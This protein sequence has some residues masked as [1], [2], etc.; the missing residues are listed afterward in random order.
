[1]GGDDGA[2]DL[3]PPVTPRAAKLFTE[4]A[5]SKNALGELRKKIEARI[6][7]LQG[8]VNQGEITLVEMA[9]RIYEL[10]WVRSELRKPFSAEKRLR[11]TGM[12][13]EHRCMENIK[14]CSDCDWVYCSIC[15]RTIGEFSS[16]SESRTHTKIHEEFGFEPPC[17]A[18]KRPRKDMT[19][20]E[21]LKRFN[22]KVVPK[23][24][25]VQFEKG[26]GAKA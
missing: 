22:M 4:K 26:S 18:E 7:F 5:S 24:A 8:R 16:I 6:K 21:F 15:D 13:V 14:Y 17:E 20:A 9:N 19:Y 3:S 12:K 1:M 11:K 25:V 23:K 10:E 2:I